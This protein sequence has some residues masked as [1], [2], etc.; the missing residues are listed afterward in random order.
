MRLLTTPLDRTLPRWV[1]IAA[2]LA[3][4]WVVPAKPVAGAA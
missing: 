4:A 1:L 3:G 2:L